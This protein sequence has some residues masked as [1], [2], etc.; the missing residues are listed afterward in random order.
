VS[1]KSYQPRQAQLNCPHE[2]NINLTTGTYGDYGSYKEKR[3]TE[4]APVEK[5]EAEAA[6]VEKREPEPKADAEAKP[7]YGIPPGWT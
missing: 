5:R 2:V 6:P 4:A 3:E 1:S 7:Q